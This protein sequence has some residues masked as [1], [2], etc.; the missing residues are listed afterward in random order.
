MF[1]KADSSRNNSVTH[2]LCDHVIVLN[3]RFLPAFM[4]LR[5]GQN[6]R[7]LFCSGF[8]SFACPP[9][10]GKM[11][12]EYGGTRWLL[13]PRLGKYLRAGKRISEG[14]SPIL[15]ERT[16]IGCQARHEFWLGRGR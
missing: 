13:L 6:A 3:R 11:D 16:E 10:F 2:P 12:P 7:H 15:K 5:T 14:A 8:S 9:V 1:S 4:H